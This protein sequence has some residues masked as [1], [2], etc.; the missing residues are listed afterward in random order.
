MIWQEDVEYITLLTNL[1]EGPK[2]KY[3]PNEREELKL[4]P[5]SVKLIEEKVYA[6]YVVRKMTLSR[7][8]V[9][10]SR[11][12]VQFHFTRWPDH[13]K[14]NPLNLIMFLRHFRH[15]MR[16]TNHPIVVHCSA[17]IGRTG[18]FIALDVLS[19]YGEE[20]D[21]INVIEFVKAMHKDRM[22]MIQ[23][24]VM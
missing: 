19:R 4:G 5:F 6:Y 2:V 22:T 1:T 18:T 10:G 8:K 23:N 11:T 15:K 9:S 14:P 7:K 13:G 16:P 20:H 3:W 24:V 17:G 21:K 12:V